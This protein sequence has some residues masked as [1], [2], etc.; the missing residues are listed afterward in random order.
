MFPEDL[1]LQRLM[2]AKWEVVRTA[3]GSR[4]ALPEALVVRYGE[5]PPDYTRFVSSIATCVHPAGDSWFL[6]LR[7][8]DGSSDAAFS[9]DDFERQSLEAA[10]GDESWQQE[11][12][13]YWDKILP[14]ALSVRSGYSYLGLSL[15]H[16]NLGAVVLGREPEFEESATVA[17]SFR[18]LC[19]AVIEHLDGSERE[20]LADFL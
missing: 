1:M 19:Q 14:I 10:V 17:P 6:G 13:S 9:W 12:R 20:E 3:E 2:A 18:E 4:A 5:L 16:D 8:F 11:I 7:D 15:G